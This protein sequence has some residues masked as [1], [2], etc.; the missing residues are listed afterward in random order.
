MKIKFDRLQLC[1][2]P[3][4]KLF[5]I[6]GQFLAFKVT[7]RALAPA[8]SGSSR[9]RAGTVNPVAFGGYESDR[10]R[11]N[12]TF[13]LRVSR[14]TLQA[15]GALGRHSALHP[16]G[17]RALD[18]LIGGGYLA[19][20]IIEA[21]V[22]TQDCSPSSRKRPPPYYHNLDNPTLSMIHCKRHT[23]AITHT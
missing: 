18:A 4:C 5:M 3:V 7:P 15:Y 17:S 10:I 19:G 8:A 21:R 1:H 13:M 14:V 2:F 9:L 23:E 12:N 11:V 22:L 20:S 6:A 16:T